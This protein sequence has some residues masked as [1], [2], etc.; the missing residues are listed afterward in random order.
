MEDLL[1]ILVAAEVH[2]LALQ[3]Q[4]RGDNSPMAALV[5][6]AYN[7]LRNTSQTIQ[8]LNQLQKSV[9]LHKS[10]GYPIPR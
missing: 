2:K 8:E 6:R 9:D 7:D 1:K 10:L 3:Y 5:A 4:E